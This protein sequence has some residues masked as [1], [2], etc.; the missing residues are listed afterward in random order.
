MKHK[1]L[2]LFLSGK[3]AVL[4]TFMSQ[5]QAAIVPTFEQAITSVLTQIEVPTAT[6]TENKAVRLDSLGTATTP[7]QA[8]L[9]TNSGVLADKLSLV[10][11]GLKKADTVFVLAS[12]VAGTAIDAQFDSRIKLSLQNAQIIMFSGIDGPANG[13]LTLSTSIELNT[14]QAK[15]IVFATG[16]NKLYLQ[17]VVVPPDGIAGGSIVWS[18]LRYSELDTLVVD[19]CAT[20]TYGTA[21]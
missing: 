21:Y 5:A 14:L 8:Y 15:G 3:A 2:G 20:G 16:S 9:C 13:T 10:I 17:T 19:R 7:G 11:T 1:F 4:P 18:K 6:V 12:S